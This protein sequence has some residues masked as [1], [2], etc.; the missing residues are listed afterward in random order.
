[1]R[2]ILRKTLNRT[3]WWALFNTAASFAYDLVNGRYMR[4]GGASTQALSLT[5]DRASS[6]LVLQGNGTYVERYGPRTNICTNYNYAGSAAGIGFSGSTPPIMTIVD[7]ALAP[8]GKAF[9]VEGQAAAG[10]G[11]YGYVLIPGVPTSG[12]EY[13]MSAQI[14][15]GV[16]DLRDSVGSGQAPFSASATYKLRTS[17]FTATTANMTL[18]VFEDEVI[19]FHSNQFELGPDV[20]PII[21]VQ[22]AAVTTEPELAIGQ[23][24]GLQV[25]QAVTNRVEYSDDFNQ[26]WV[27]GNISFTPNDRQSPFAG[28]MADKIS[29]AIGAANSGTFKTYDTGVALADNSF[30]VAFMIYS[31]V[32]FSG[33]IRMRGNGVT[34]E[35]ENL[36]V[37]IPVGWSRVPVTKTF[38]SAASGTYLYLGLIPDFGASPGRTW[39]Q[40]N[41]DVVLGDV[42]YP[43]I[44]CEGSFTTRASDNPVVVQGLGDEVVATWNTPMLWGEVS[45]N[46]T[47][48]ADGSVRIT[49]TGGATYN[50]ADA[51]DVVVE[52]GV[53]YLVV[54]KFRAGTSPNAR[55]N[56]FNSAS[57]SSSTTVAGPVGNLSVNNDALG[58][59][60]G[61][62]QTL[63]AD[64]VWTVTFLFTS[65]INSSALR[66]GLG[67]HTSAVGQTITA[68][69]SSVKQVLPYPGYNTDGTL[70]GRELVEGGGFDTQEDVDLWQELNEASITLSNGAMR[71]TNT[72]INNGGGLLRL[73]DLRDGAVFKFTGERVADNDPGGAD[74]H[75]G[76]TEGYGTYA[77]GKS[78]SV[79]PRYFLKTVPGDV[80]VYAL[81]SGSAIGTWKEHD[82]I[83]LQEVEPGVV[84]E[85][86]GVWGSS[87]NQRVMRLD[88]GSSNNY[89]EV[90][91]ESSGKIKLIY[92]KDGVQQISITQSTVWPADQLATFRLELTNTEGGFFCALFLDDEYQGL[93]GGP[94]EYAEA[95]NELDISPVSGVKTITEIYGK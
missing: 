58:A 29:S 41:V 12:L 92:V 9:K 19:Y 16:G 44:I 71:V 76:S 46:L 86:V 10:S 47:E 77:A 32:A 60:A 26:W 82:N 89:L 6:A 62:T 4:S 55:I 74:Y 69:S 64:G 31:E 75:I 91:R 65:A 17:T 48:N 66:L 35:A 67:P 68:I 59:V 83:S 50:R 30:T 27:H 80:R 78:Y 8:E 11:L 45:V 28:R 52:I 87:N 38:T 43:P 39:W 22:G 53:T 20:T 49:P 23:S 90:R 15:G 18:S 72:A 57:G 70:S 54:V 63:G 85:A 56:L 61:I 21:E 1:M 34:Q 7:D 95:I 25:S 42:L 81:L 93:S 84:I 5:E 94:F 33:V 24:V 88:D 51:E 36:P 79:G 13:T 14:R 2:P 37:E 40:S 3:R 73:F